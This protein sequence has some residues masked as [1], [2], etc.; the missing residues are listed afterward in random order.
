[1][2]WRVLSICLVTLVVAGTGVGYFAWIGPPASSIEAQVPASESAL[3]RYDLSSDPYA[4]VALPGKLTEISGL[5]VREDGRMFAFGDER[6]VIYELDVSR[7]EIVKSFAL[8]DRI[9]RGDF[10]GL[11][12]AEGRFY[13]VTSDGII[14]ETAEGKDGESVPFE[15]RITGL[16]TECEIEGLG[17]DPASRTLLLACKECRKLA[18]CDSVTVFRWSIVTKAVARAATLRIP[19]SVLK[20]A[21][22]NA[23]NP[24]GIERD[25]QTGNYLVVSAHPRAII[26]ITP[27]GKLVASA[28]LAKRWHPQ[29]EGIAILPNLTLAVSDEGSKKGRRGSLALYASRRKAGGGSR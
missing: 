18:L 11:A 19:L 27:A 24:S 23:F 29:S 4:R 20:G 3:S 26:E 1:M 21:G 16:G 7:G 12:I 25:P 13:I 2:K 22:L 14:Y 5:A 6:A 28:K 8:G 10:E 15:R 17:Y 9:I